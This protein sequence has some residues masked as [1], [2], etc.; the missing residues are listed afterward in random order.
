MLSAISAAVRAEK[1]EQ[2]ALMAATGRADDRH[3]F[4]WVA[5]WL[6]PDGRVYVR[7]SRQWWICKKTCPKA[8]AY[9][10]ELNADGGLMTRNFHEMELRRLTG[11]RPG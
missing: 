5:P 4:T 8:A 9:Q 2:T 1:A 10:R 11:W 6:R 3:V 7:I